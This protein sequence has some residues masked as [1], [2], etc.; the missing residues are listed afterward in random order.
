MEITGR[1]TQI[2][3]IQTIQGKKGD[4][5]KQN[6]LIETL[7]KF[8][9]KVCVTLWNNTIADLSYNIGDAV[10]CSIDIESRE[11]QGKYY[12]D[13]KAWKVLRPNQGAPPPESRRSKEA[14]LDRHDDYSHNQPT[15]NPPA[16]DLDD[17]DLPF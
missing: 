12:T 16:S 1:I 14:S 5:I 4:L 17:S 6:F 13:I 2:D 7:D 8:P 11:Y 15:S 9:K 3:P 10:V